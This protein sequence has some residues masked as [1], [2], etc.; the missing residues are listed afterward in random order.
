MYLRCIKTA[1]FLT[2]KL[3]YKP[4]FRIE[5]D[6]KNCKRNDIMCQE[7]MTKRPCNSTQVNVFF[8]IYLFINSKPITRTFANQIQ[9]KV[10][11]GGLAGNSKVEALMVNMGYC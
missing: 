6:K 2:I 8:Q 3:K 10:L 5:K 4:F 9:I 7:V 11:N 1:D